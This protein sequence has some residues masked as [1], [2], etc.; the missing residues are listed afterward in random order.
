M[1]L[2]VDT[3]GINMATTETLLA[4]VPMSP[5][6]TLFRNFLDFRFADIAKTTKHKCMVFH[7]FMQKCWR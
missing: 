1:A 4:T 3:I 2:Y 6:P 5:S 7:S